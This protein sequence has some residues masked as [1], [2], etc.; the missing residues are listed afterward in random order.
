MTAVAQLRVCMVCGYRPTPGG[1]GTEKHVYELACGLRKRGVDVDIICEDRSFLPDDNHQPGDH[2]IGID[3]ESLHASGWVQ[4]YLE[5]SRR[6][7]EVLNASRYDVVHC[8]NHY[9]FDSALKLARL[10]KAPILFST[11]HL[12]PVGILQ[13]FEQLGL[14]EKD[15]AE[16]DRAVGIMEQAQARLS[17]RC[18]AVS[19]C[20]AREVIELYGVPAERVRLVYNWYDDRLFA[21]HD[22]EESRLELGLEPHGRYLLY[23]GHFR[24]LRGWLLRGAMRLLPD[25]VKLIAVHPQA[26]DAILAEFGDRILFTGYVPAERMPLYY[27][28]ADAQCF[29]P[30]YGAFGLVLVEGMAC[31]CPPIVFDYPA[32]SE[33]VTPQSGYLVEEPTPEAYAAAI[34]RALADRHTKRAGAI[35]RAR[36]FDMETQIDQV[37]T[38]YWE[39][40]SERKPASAI[41]H[42]CA[43]FAVE[44]VRPTAASNDRHT[45]PTPAR[46]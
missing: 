44:S 38:L 17:D 33:V 39:S 29:P 14:P 40:V 8:H 46:G 28:A 10:P 26:D 23:V 11:Y 37:L 45:A 27:S 13:R 20:V 18:I 3:P 34:E 9:G 5:K 36:C 22:Y 7:A 43:A 31:G 2:I 16:I 12:T 30:V 35:E 41:P 19:G 15:G 32:M 21:P 4:Q 25:H 42:R 1:G 24:E 6:F